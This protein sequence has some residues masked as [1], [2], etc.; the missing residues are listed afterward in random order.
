MCIKCEIAKMALKATGK[1]LIEE[2]VGTIGTAFV[3]ELNQLEE[4]HD[5]LEAQVKE[6]SDR[7]IEEAVNKIEAE[8]KTKYGKKLNDLVDLQ[9]KVLKDAFASAGINIDL[10][11]TDFSVNKKTGVVTTREVR[12]AATT[13]EG[14]H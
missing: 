1:E 11:K 7:L 3:K 8:V 13:A 5:V 12:D 14:V 2:K 6:E 9:Q 10:H 4:A